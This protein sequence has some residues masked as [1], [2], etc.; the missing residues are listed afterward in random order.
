[1][2]LREPQG[3]AFIEF[4]DERDA[5]YAKRKLDREMINGREISVLYAKVR[6]LQYSLGQSRPCL[7]N[8]LLGVT[9][10]PQAT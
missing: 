1:V 10:K 2:V 3:F 7:I 6:P 9:A 4:Y 5:D 8:L